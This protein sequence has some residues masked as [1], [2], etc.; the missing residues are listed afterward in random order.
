MKKIKIVLADDHQLFLDGTLNL[1]KMEEDIEVVDTFRDGNTLLN[2]LD[3]H[4]S[5][6]CLL[7]LD[8]NLPLKNGFEVLNALQ[9][10]KTKPSILMLSMY[11]HPH[12][13][14]QAMERGADGYVY[15]DHGI[16]KLL[17]AIRDISSGKKI[18]SKHFYQDTVNKIPVFSER[19]LQILGCI[20]KGQT[21]KI[22]AQNLQISFHTVETHRKNLLRKAGQHSTAGLIDY[23]KK[24][25]PAHVMLD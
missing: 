7:I 9:E 19:E 18:M 22:I 23:F 11:N 21:S 20:I 25:L 24:N 15:K 16:D 8:I 6:D 5:D 3:H 12:F 14:M 2:F 1:L 10:K 13:V 17:K 4:P